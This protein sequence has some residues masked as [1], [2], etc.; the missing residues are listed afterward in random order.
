MKAPPFE[1]M[2]AHLQAVLSAAV[3]ENDDDWCAFTEC[4]FLDLSER[5]IDYLE[6][7]QVALGNTRAALNIAS[8][9]DG[10]VPKHENG[11]VSL[12]TSAGGQNVCGLELAHLRE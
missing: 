10:S 6:P 8:D 4:G 3:I 12:F 7:K 9:C 5:K 2:D 11:R 1:K